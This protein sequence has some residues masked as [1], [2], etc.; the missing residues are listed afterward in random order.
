M[1]WERWRI[2]ALFAP[3]LIVIVILFG[4]GR[5]SLYRAGWKGIF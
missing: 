4:G 1:R 2:P 5:F 3:A